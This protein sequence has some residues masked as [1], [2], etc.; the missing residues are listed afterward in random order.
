[1]SLSIRGRHTPGKTLFLLVDGQGEPY[2]LSTYFVPD[3]PLTPV[4]FFLTYSNYI[5]P[6][7]ADTPGGGT[8]GGDAYLNPNPTEKFIVNA[9]QAIYC[10]AAG[11]GTAF[12][13]FNSLEDDD[14]FFV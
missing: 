4:D 11:P 8:P 2:A 3:D 7:T 9:G 1:M 5:L 14:A 13:Q 6:S 10:F 12:A